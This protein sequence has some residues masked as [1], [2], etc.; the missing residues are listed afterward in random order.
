MIALWKAEYQKTRGR[1][2]FLFVFAMS[3]VALACVVGGNLSEDA[4]AKGWYMLLYQMPLINALMLPVMAMLLSFRLGDLEHKNGMFKQLCCITEKGKLFD[5]KLL[6]G[7]GLMLIGIVIQWCGIIAD[8]LFR[9]HFGGSFLWKEY[10]LLLLFT[11][12][13]TAAIYVLQHVVVMCCAKPTVPYAVGIIGEFAGVLSLFLP[14]EWFSNMMPWGYYGALIL[15]R[16]DYDRATRISTYYYREVNWGGFAAVSLMTIV[17][18][19][20]GRMIFCRKEV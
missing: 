5:A 3:A 7:F 4:I 17:F 15:I 6:Y 11:I 9:H 8:G 19:V 14:Y 16:A 13:P 1:H 20:V 10:L 12:A 2:L 18:Y